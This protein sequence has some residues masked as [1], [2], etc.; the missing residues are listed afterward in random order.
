MLRAPTYTSHRIDNRPR[1]PL[2]RYYARQDQ[3]EHRF[4]FGVLMGS[5]SEIE[6]CTD[7]KAQVHNE[8]CLAVS[9]FCGGYEAREYGTFT[10]EGVRL[11]T[12]KQAKDQ[13]GYVLRLF[14]YHDAEAQGRVCISALGLDFSLPF[15][16][17]E[18]KTVRVE[19][20]AWREVNLLTEQ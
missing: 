1:L 6:A 17:Q 12:C 3:G 16:G 2:E 4:T 10:V 15:A 18:I 14:N 7:L 19:P 13:R 11:D 9:A 8:P 20:G 5:A